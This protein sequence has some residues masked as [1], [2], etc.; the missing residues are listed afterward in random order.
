C[1]L[2]G[3]TPGWVDPGRLYPETSSYL[4]E[5]GDWQFY[6]FL[7]LSFGGAP[8]DWLDISL[9]NTMVGFSAVYFAAFGSGIF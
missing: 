7:K 1:E 5:S 9:G 6:L 3:H 8:G 4:C 2:S